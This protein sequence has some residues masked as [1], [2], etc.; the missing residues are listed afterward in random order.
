MLRIAENLPDS[1]RRRFKI[2]VVPECLYR[3][4]S[5]FGLMP[6]KTCHSLNPETLDPRFKHSGTT[7]MRGVEN[8]GGGICS[9]L[10]AENLPDSVRRRIQDFDL[11]PN[12][13]LN[14]PFSKFTSDD[15]REFP[16]SAFLANSP[17]GGF[18]ACFA[19]CLSRRDIPF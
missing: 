9:L 8:A 14:D 18:A 16:A 2:T 4:S 1:V 5:G 19:A 6:L 15:P 17:A 12:S 10:A 11:S 7:G 13:P 3:E